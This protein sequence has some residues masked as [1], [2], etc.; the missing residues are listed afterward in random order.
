M[1]KELLFFLT[2]LFNKTQGQTIQNPPKAFQSEIYSTPEKKPIE[3]EAIVNI[4]VLN[5][6]NF[7]KTGSS[8]YY[9]DKDSSIVTVNIPKQSLITM[10]GGIDLR[11]GLNCKIYFNKKDSFARYI[12]KG[13]GIL[14]TIVPSFKLRPIEVIAILENIESIDELE[15]IASKEE[16]FKNWVK[17]FADGKEF[18]GKATLYKEPQLSVEL[19][20]ALNKNPIYMNYQF[21]NDKGKIKFDNYFFQPYKR[22]S[23]SAKVYRK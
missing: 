17:I 8:S 21:S 12:Q 9:S 4:R 6:I 2:I 11:K 20:S 10:L 15:K 19:A 16:V 18:Y 14:D 22:I 13:K 1:F 3:K 5:A 23:V 7:S